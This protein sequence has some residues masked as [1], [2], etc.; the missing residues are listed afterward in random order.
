MNSDEHSFER[1]LADADWRSL[2]TPFYVYD[3][4]ELT[5][6]STTLSKLFLGLFEPSYA[7]KSNPNL[8]VLRQVMKQ[9][10]HID[11]SSAHEVERALAIGLE[12]SQ[13]TW[14]GP[15]KR[16]SELRAIVGLGVSI[17]VEAEDEIELIGEIATAAGVRQD[18]LLRINPDHVP[19]GFGASMSG[20]PSQFGIDETKAAG[21]I[22]RIMSEPALKLTGFHAYTGSMCLSPEPIAENIANLCEIFSRAS[23]AAGIVPEKLIFGAGFGIPLHDGQHA[24][25]IEQVRDLVA[26]HIEKLSRDPVLGNAK[27]LLELGRWISGPSGA[28]VTSVLSSKVSRDMPIAVCDAGFNNHLAAAGM[29]GSV[30]QKNYPFV[31]LRQTGEGI[32]AV[33]QMLAGPLCTSIDQLSRK[34]SLPL[35]HRGDVLAV[36]MSGAYGLTASPT[37]FISHPEPAEYALQQGA[38]ADIT[39]SSLNHLGTLTRLNVK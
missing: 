9:L 14:S 35:L 1:R 20:R 22:A 8:A 7:I 33:E 31:V 18:V 17:V 12:P 36:M 6:R 32:E 16:A 39:E 29:M 26:P 3:L 5:A 28:L 4:D 19:K 13:I 30:F 15:G 34:I 21:A 11:A 24:L 37:R 23:E 25:D 38:L 27:R 10:D 2:D